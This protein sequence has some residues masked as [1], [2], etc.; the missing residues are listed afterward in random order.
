MYE[1]TYPHI[2]CSFIITLSS[3]F[4]QIENNVAHLSTSVKNHIVV[5]WLV[6][7]LLELGNGVLATDH[8]GLCDE[9]L[10]VEARQWFRCLLAPLTLS[11][12][13]YWS[14]SAYS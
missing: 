7:H 4:N 2:S 13:W 8:L 9:S 5:L 12:W 3:I 11:L 10:D 14:M 6:K 1:E